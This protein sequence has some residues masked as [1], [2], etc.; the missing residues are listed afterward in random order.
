MIIS[1]SRRTDI[2]NYYGEW[3]INRIKEGFLCVRNPMN[4]HQVSKISLSPEV[5][6]CIVFWTKNPRNMMGRL[7][8]LKDYTYYFQFT[9]TG[10]GKDVERNLP[11]KR[12]VMIPTFQ[13]LSDWIGAE[14]VIWR[15]DPILF[16]ETYTPEYHLKAFQKIAKSL[17][18]YT[19]KVVISFVDS[20]VKN[21]K[22]MANLK[23][24]ELAEDALND[25]ARSLAQMAHENDMVIATCAERIDLESC[26]IEHNCC[27]DKAL[28]ER[29]VGADMKLK[30]DSVQREEC[31]CM[32]SVEVGVYNTCLNG[33][34]YCYASYN[35]D[36]VLKNHDRLDVN[37]PILCGEILSTDKV[38]ERKMKSLKLPRDNQLSL[39]ADD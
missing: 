17:R 20:Y 15:Y 39:F 10:Y 4:V 38:T 24:H 33:C 3:F 23:T 16:N 2:P 11:D 19:E 7:D 35:S 28:I 6:D 8:E 1:A 30:K 31:G 12:T 29:L 36:S 32:E 26:G 14:R 9:L 13:E 25:F 21:R 5:V 27:I 37:S 18:G 34:D 22:S